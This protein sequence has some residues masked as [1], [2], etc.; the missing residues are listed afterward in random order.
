MTTTHLSEGLPIVSQKPCRKRCTSVVRKEF[1][2]ATDEATP[3]QLIGEPYQG[4]RPAPGYPAQP[5]HTEKTTR[6]ACSTP[7][8]GSASS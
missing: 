3:D 4:I 5:D 6:S 8:S 2:G 7:N 1:W